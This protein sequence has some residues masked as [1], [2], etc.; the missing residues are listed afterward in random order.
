MNEQPLSPAEHEQVRGVILAGARRIKPHGAHRKAFL[1]GAVAFVL[2]SGIS[3]GAVATAAYFG[4]SPAPVSSPT[5]TPSPTPETTST[6]TPSPT[7]TITLSP[8]TTPAVAFDGICENALS[9]A[10]VTEAVGM[11]MELRPFRWESGETTLLGGI[12]CLWLSTDVY[13]AAAVNLYVYPEQVVAASVRE[14][15]TTGCVGG[16]DSTE[17][18]ATAVTS[19]GAWYALRATRAGAMAFEPVES[20]EQALIA[21][22]SNFA[23]PAPEARTPAWWA[24]PDCAEVVGAVEPSAVGHDRREPVESDSSDSTHPVAIPSLA[25]AGSSCTL[26]FSSG[27]GDSKEWFR[28]WI[29]FVPG[30]GASYGDIASADGAS[31]ID[32]PGARGAVLVPGNDRYEGSPSVVAVTDGTNLLLIDTSVAVVNGEVTGDIEAVSG[33]AASLLDLLERG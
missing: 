13:M 20:L 33:V 29:Q 26:E 6:P 17:C 7:P 1:A 9:A 30:A 23:P 21:R 25:G 16:P 3:G 24:L 11:P 32:I 4:T 12:D 15:L 22:L 28:T 10:E 31:A 14:A 19:A 18:T 8:T 27:E 5:P 2:I